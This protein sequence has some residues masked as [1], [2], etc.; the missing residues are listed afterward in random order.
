MK[1]KR[2]IVKI[3]S[4]VLFAALP[5]GQKVRAAGGV[6]LPTNVGL[7]SATIPVIVEGLVRWLLYIFG[8]LA[9]ISFLISGIMYLTAAGDEKTQEKAKNQMKWSIIGVIVGLAGLVV[10]AAIDNL[11]RGG[12]LG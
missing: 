6:T 2:T 11:L 1:I 10:I 7:P 12:G 8:F 3:S 9:I 5:L 4:L